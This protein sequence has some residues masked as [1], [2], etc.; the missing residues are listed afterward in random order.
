MADVCLALYPIELGGVE[1]AWEQTMEEMVTEEGKK[2]KVHVAGWK[3]GTDKR[4]GEQRSSKKRRV[5]TRLIIPRVESRP[6]IYQCKTRR[7]SSA[8]HGAGRVP[9]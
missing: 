3:E 9:T 2:G 6:F 5:P 1:M 8:S 7:R 4:F